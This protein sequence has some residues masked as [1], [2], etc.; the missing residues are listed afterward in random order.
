VGF[1]F[2]TGL[3]IERLAS[4]R[5]M[6]FDKTGTLTT[7]QP[8]VS[9]FAI[10]DGAAKPYLLS[11]VGALELGS[12]HILA[13]E[14]VRY[15]RAQGVEFELADEIYEVPGHGVRGR[16][17]GRAIE[18]GSESFIADTLAIASSTMPQAGAGE[19]RSYVAVDRKLAGYFAFADRVRSDLPKM[20]ADLRD[21]GVE[22]T[23]ILSGDDEETVRAVA[24]TLQIDEVHAE[25]KPI[26]KV[27]HVERIKKRDG[28][29]AMI[30]DGVND[31]PALA[32]SDIGIA[33]AARG[34]GIAAET[35]DV[36]LLGQDLARIA[37]GVGIARRTLRIA[38]QSIGVGLGLSAVAMIIASAGYISPIAG[39]VYQEV[40]DVLVI[41]NALRAA[42]AP[43]SLW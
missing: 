3:A 13:R 8:Q 4:V 38:H 36:V 40:L 21:L 37:D 6:I 18:I 10:L 25:L 28:V 19:L 14:V 1:L 17:D 32:A 20:F 22:H 26:D 24:G 34:G 30:G 31:A 5:A 39:A 23:A 33:V 35:A 15:A 9:S 12:S 7:G 29:T 41:L 27:G 11:A 43:R 2:R 16:V 42:A